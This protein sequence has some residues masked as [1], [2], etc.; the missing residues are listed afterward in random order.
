MDDDED[1]RFIAEFMLQ[2]L[3]FAVVLTTKGTEAIK[4]YQEALDMGDT[5]PCGNS[6]YQYTGEHGR[7]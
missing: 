2:Q 4:R 1:V 7:P 5:L 3:G 6:R